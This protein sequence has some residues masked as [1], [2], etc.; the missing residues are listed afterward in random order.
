M[1]LFLPALAL[2]AL[3]TMML[4]PSVAVHLPALLPMSLC[5]RVAFSLVGTNC[6]FAFQPF[7]AL[8]AD[9]ISSTI[10][11]WA[12]LILGVFFTPAWIIE[13]F[14][15]VVVSIGPLATAVSTAVL[16]NH[17]VK[18]SRRWSRKN[19]EQEELPEGEQ[20][21]KYKIYILGAS[22]L[23]LGL[24]VR[25]TIQFLM[26][27]QT[28]T[29]GHI[30]QASVVSIVSSVLIVRCLIARRAVLS[31]S[32][33]VAA[34][35]SLALYQFGR[36]SAAH[37]RLPATEG[38]LYLDTWLPNLL[39]ASGLILLAWKLLFTSSVEDEAAEMRSRLRRLHTTA[40]TSSTMISLVRAGVILLL[41]HMLQS[42]VAL[43]ALVH[44]GEKAWWTTAAEHVQN[45]LPVMS[46]WLFSTAIGSDPSL[47]AASFPVHT[48]RSL[49]SRLS[50]LLASFFPYGLASACRG[51]TA[52]VVCWRRLDLS[53]EE[54][55]EQQEQ[56]ETSEKED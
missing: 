31:E 41:M 25:W 29:V 51:V 24:A 1:V 23:F 4:L 50:L 53:E 6:L 27:T 11:S 15:V 2:A 42:Q 55:E 22:I 21:S 8:L 10:V 9:G 18:V 7:A 47:D 5:Y 39:D 34:L 32:C 14:T 40:T 12:G 16:I 46:A 36:W 37:E 33:F 48:I 56:G 43:A 52:G 49:L 28:I 13:A 44:H 38:N 54:E 3:L 17:A 20:S 19:G 26:L 45:V 35:L 30:V